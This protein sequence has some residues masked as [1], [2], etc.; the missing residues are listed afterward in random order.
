MKSKISRIITAILSLALFIG[1]IVT[2]VVSANTLTLYPLAFD[3][4]VLGVG[5]DVSKK[6]VNWY[7][8]LSAHGAVD[9]AP[10]ENMVDGK[11]PEEY[12]TADAKTVK[13][14]NKPGYY[15][16]S[17]TITDLKENT[18]YVYRLRQGSTVSSVYHFNTGSFGDSEFVFV[19]DPQVK[20]TNDSK[21]WADTLKKIN[22]GAIFEKAELLISAGDQVGTSGTKVATAEAELHWSNFF[23]DELTE[24]TLAPTAGP[25]HDIASGDKVLSSY[26]ERFYR[27]N[28][29][30]K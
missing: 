19:G 12:E 13:S 3:D 28:A 17:A 22:N 20:G 2:V 7:S 24:I 8:T 15:V 25:A 5:A 26:A 4:V 1:V 29:S 16:N 14:N 6:I 11:F 23:V 30:D 21:M 27:P 10:Y 9:W 18:E